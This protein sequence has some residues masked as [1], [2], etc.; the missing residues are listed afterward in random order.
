VRRGPA[1]LACAIAAASSACPEPVYDDDIG[2][3]GVPTEPGALAGAFV[4]AMT[5]ADLGDVPGFGAQYAGG[6]TFMLVRRTWNGSAYEQTNRVCAV[7][8]FE[9]AGL[10]TEVSRRTARSIPALGVE[11]SIDHATGAYGAADFF[12]L[13]A[14]QGLE[15]GAPLPTSADDPRVW[16]MDA[17]GKVGATLTTSGLLTGELY[18]AQRKTVS[19]S[20]VVRGPDESVGLLV[21]KKEAVVLDATDELLKQKVERAQHPDPKE[22]WWHEVRIAPAGG[23]ADCGDV[24]AALADGTLALRPF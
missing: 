16:D 13:W 8:N 24:E 20:G 3:S 14:L 9:V 5:A 10:A 7:V 6:M 12:E 2:L 19:L 17:D 18:V 21:H 4:L 23:G 22:S 1:L 11:L 15:R